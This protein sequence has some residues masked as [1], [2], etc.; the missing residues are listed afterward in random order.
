MMMMMMRMMM[1]MMMMIKLSYEIIVLLL[2]LNL[3]FYFSCILKIISMYAPK[4]DQSFCIKGHHRNLFYISFWHV[5]SSIS[6]ATTTT[7]VTMAFAAQEPRVTVFSLSLYNYIFILSLYIYI[8]M[9][10]NI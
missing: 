4:L 2:Y 3:T 9:H 7:P 1:M 8:S 6:K 5:L 10:V